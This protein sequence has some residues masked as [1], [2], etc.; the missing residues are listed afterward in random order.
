MQKS[1]V[2][3]YDE[4]TSSVAPKR[5]TR[6]AAASRHRGGFKKLRVTTRNASCPNRLGDCAATH[7][8]AL[9]GYTE[10]PKVAEGSFFSSVRQ[11]DLM[12][13]YTYIRL[14][15]IAHFKVIRDAR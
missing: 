12:R 3:A 4:L 10:I 13:L 7:E 9:N 14:C 1:A 6:P 2:E 8:L 15:E 11:K 5:C